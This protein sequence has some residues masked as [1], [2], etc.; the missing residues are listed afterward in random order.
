[1]TGR[2]QT[3][4]LLY[5]RSS[6]NKS[7]ATLSC[8]GFALLLL[9]PALLHAQEKPLKWGE[10]PRA[11]LEM[12][13][14]PADSNATAVILGDYGE[15]YF[16]DDVNMVFTRHRRIKILSA[17]GYEWGSHTIDYNVEARH[18]RVSHIEGQTLKLADGAV[19]LDKLDKAAVFDE[20]V[21]DSIRRIRFTLPALAPGAVV[22]YRY[23][24]NWS[25]GFSGN[26]HDWSFQAGEPTRWS[27]FRVAIPSDNRFLNMHFVIVKENIPALAIEESTSETS[28]LALHN[29][30]YYFSSRGSTPVRQETRHEQIVIKRQRWAMQ[31]VPALRREP[32]ITTLDDYRARLYFQLAEINAAGMRSLKF[33]PTWEKVAKGLIDSPSFG[34]QIERRGDWCEQAETLIANC[35]DAEQKI[36]VIYD[37]VRATIKY[38]GSYGAYA[39]DLGKA[40][41]ARRGTDEDIALLLTSMLR[42]AGL[43]A[44]PMFIS[45]RDHGKI[46]KVYPLLRQF[47]RVL[48]YAKAGEREYFLDATDPLRPYNLLPAEALT[49][50]GWVVE[51][52][53]S[54]WVGIAAP[55]TFHSYT[56][57]SAKLAADGSLTGW[58]E[59]G[60]SGY[61]A[62]HDR[63]SLQ[64]KKED[65]YVREGWINGLV[66]AKLD[67]FRISN[68]DSVN[69]P[70]KIKAYFSSSGYAPDGGE[71][72]YFNPIFFGRREEN[73]FN[74]NYSKPR[75]REAKKSMIAWFG[76]KTTFK[77]S[78]LNAF[79]TLCCSLRT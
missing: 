62:L 69:T 12:T 32:F 2:R 31:N 21:N 56:T 46:L 15:V 52:K 65:E 67:S 47:N 51:K 77:L 30:Y 64:D 3:R 72:I 19:R 78:F 35:S 20:E 34:E 76:I 50:A 39:G 26:L 38:T 42:C 7:T 27:E 53:T 57:V 63:R 75:R 55:E 5:K 1:M 4:A 59:A 11:D 40:F 48:T 44:H 33:A 28:A 13:T 36:R 17:A 22:E 45:T 14:F 68:K 70:L 54:R 71:N 9:L 73:P 10:V 23:T 66:G 61:H 37:Y 29:Y 79:I 25:R 41:Q 8:A 58:L 6:C 24:V 18:Q 74:L 60:Q 49:N 43:E 16:D